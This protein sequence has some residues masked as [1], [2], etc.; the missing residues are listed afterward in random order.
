M[1]F[2][3][4][5]QWKMKWVELI[6]VAPHKSSIVLLG[7]DEVLNTA[8]GDLIRSNCNVK[9]CPDKTVQ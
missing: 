4:E 3:E 7:R 1:S 6:F 5:I 9:N 2:Y 8:E